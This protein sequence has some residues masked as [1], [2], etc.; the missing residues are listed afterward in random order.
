MIVERPFEIMFLPDRLRSD[1]TG[2]LPEAV[3]GAVEEREKNFLTRALAAF[4][5]H[6]LSGCTCVEAAA[7]VV[8]GGGDGGIDAIY[9]A[10]TSN[11]L[12]VVQSKY[13]ESGRGEPSLGDV[14]KF[15]NGLEDLLQG[16]FEA[17]KKN[18]LWSAQLSQIERYF[19]DPVLRVRAVLVYSGINLVSED[20][21]R[22]FEDL[23]RR[24]SSADDYFGFLPYNLTTVNGWLT[25]ADEGPGVSEVELEILYP[26]WV[27]APYETIYGLVYL[28]DI[29]KLHRTHGKRLIAANIRGYKGATEVNDRILA[30]LREE[31]QHFFYLNNGLTAYCERLEVNNLDRGNVDRKRLR[32]RGFSIINGAQTLGSVEG[33][34][35]ANPEAAPDGFVFLKLI[36]LERCEEDQ[37]FAQRITQSTNFQNQIGARDFVSLD[38]QQER[39]ALQL[40]LASIEYHY[41]DDAETPEP[42]ETNLTLDE[43][44]IALACL[45]QEATCDLCSRVLAN[46]KSLWSFERVY[47]EGE[48]YRTR[49]HRVFRP[50]RSAR[51]VWRAVQA[52]RSVLERMRAEGR[53][54]VGIR[55]TFFE[56]ARWLVLNLV[57]LK[58]HPE[59]GED[60]TLCS[61][62]QAAIAGSTLEIAEALWTACEK[63][64]LVSK[65]TDV[66]AGELHEQ[67]RHFRSV[68]CDPAD[69]QRLRNATLGLLAKKPGVP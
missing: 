15:K 27:K 53:T 19:G 32:A 18:T 8:D 44:T 17:F 2:C 67:Q 34:C 66:A 63:Q 45:E 22:M 4:A 61:E 55:K 48:L 7:A 21:L 10:P 43:A 51:T 39:I 9:Y 11:T 50:D 3:T 58:L 42:D 68:F 20:R 64:G 1:F 49:Y 40:R 36:S 56:N 30:T 41:K 5:I 31:P 29:A 59:Q 33:S 46:R 16:R 14:S 35:R 47:P 52:Q 69:C 12:W 24:F 60:L 25:D 54:S 13:M 37:E 62:E 23:K 26:G 57:F 65:R 6:K 28:K 38:E